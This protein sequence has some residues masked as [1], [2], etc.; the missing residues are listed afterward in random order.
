MRAGGGSRDIAR[1][2]FRL[3]RAFNRRASRVSTRKSSINLMNILYPRFERYTYIAIYIYVYK[4]R[5]DQMY[6]RS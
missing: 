5:L 6:A 2:S 4:T 1:G 3:E